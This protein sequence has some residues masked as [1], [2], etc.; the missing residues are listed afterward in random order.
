[1]AV[2]IGRYTFRLRP[3]KT[4]AR[5][6]AEEGR[7]A[8]WVWNQCVRR[9]REL[10]AEG[11]KCGPAGLDRELTDWRNTDENWSRWLA[12][13]SSVVQQQ[14]VR[15]FAAARA[16]ALADIKAR[17][18]V[19]QRRGL[20]RFHSYADTL[21]S[22]NYT[23]RAFSV[24]DG[25]LCLA[26][27]LLIPVVWSRDLPSEPKSARVYR[28]AAGQWWASFVVRRQVEDLAENA[29]TIGVDWGV[30][31]TA[32]TTNSSF[33]LP[34]RRHGRS[35]QP[36]VARAQRKMARRRR[37]AGQKPSTGYLV[38]KRKTA[39][40]YQKVAWQRAD[41]AHKWAGW[42]VAEHHRIAVEDFRPKFLA[43][44]SMARKAADAA[45]GQTKRILI[46]HATR[47]G[48]D[49]RLVAPAYTTMDCAQCG[50]RAK[51]RLPLSERT[52]SCKACGTVK[53][54][55]RNS[56]AVMVARAGF[57]TNTNVG[58]AIELDGDPAGA[59]SVR[60]DHPPGARAA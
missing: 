32:V 26:G 45:I 46:E 6:L 57:C 16:K 11:L 38:A 40:L 37:P 42:V 28:D 3:S 58:A 51:H 8:T 7:R 56:A 43:R 19:T 31:E 29:A 9:S 48:R 41:D 35:A 52:Y 27:D 55:D 12:S 30:T 39:R 54:R 20:P 60:L 49:L 2:Q 15:D 25:R 21:P 4:V 14:A 34:H 18:S 33:D 47:A 1:M 24:R 17:V 5:L 59:E 23:T 36:R 53:P 44:S 13:G 50:A 10:R 22:M